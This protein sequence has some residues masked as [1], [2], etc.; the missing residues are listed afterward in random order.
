M[1]TYNT[2]EIT[3]EPSTSHVWKVCLRDVGK[4]LGYFSCKR[5]K[6]ACQLEYHLQA[7]PGY[8]LEALLNIA[9]VWLYREQ[10][11]YVDVYGCPYDIP[12]AKGN[13]ITLEDIELYGANLPL[14]EIAAVVMENDAGQVLLGL[15]PDGLIIPG[16]W[17]FPGGKLEACED[18]IAAGIREI[19]EELG[20][21][22]INPE[23]LLQF[24]YSFIKN[25]LRGTL[26]WTRIWKGDLR[27]LHHKE[28]RWVDPG[29]LTDYPMPLSNI[30]FDCFSMLKGHPTLKRVPIG[31]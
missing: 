25:R 26:L 5:Q 22:I 13:R 27:N 4:D 14:V 9:L 3:I 24:N 15:R 2:D 12:F 17:E 23:P 7:F 6:D 29:V 10:V 11:S 28:L 1:I 19:R 21:E 20:V 8:A 16:L 30:L 18:A 31:Y